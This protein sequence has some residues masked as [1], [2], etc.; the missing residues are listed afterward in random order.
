MEEK[1]ITKQLDELIKDMSGNVIKHKRPI[2]KKGKK[3]RE[4]CLPDCINTLRVCSKYILFDLEATKRE[5]IYL[6]RLLNNK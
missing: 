3:D 6:K 4:P 1:E 2:L 5:N